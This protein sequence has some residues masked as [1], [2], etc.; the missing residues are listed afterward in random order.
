M[1]RGGTVLIFTAAG[2]DET[3]PVPINDIFWRSEVTITS[4]YAGS[5]QDHI[6]AMEKIRSRKISVHDMI[7]HRFPLKDAGMGFKLV[8]EAGE[9]IK[10]I[11]E[12]QK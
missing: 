11:I 9:S 2:K 4:S 8:A 5:P 6:E 10:V 12:P 7:T 1:E 3:L